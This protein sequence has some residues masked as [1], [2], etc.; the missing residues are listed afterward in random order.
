M[1]FFCHLYLPQEDHNIYRACAKAIDDVACQ[2]LTIAGSRYFDDAGQKTDANSY[3]GCVPSTNTGERTDRPHRKSSSEGADIVHKNEK[4]DE[5][6]MVWRVVSLILE[7]G[8]YLEVEVDAEEHYAERER[9]RVLSFE[10]SGLR[11]GCVVKLLDVC[12][13]PHI[14]DGRGLTWV[15]IG[16]LR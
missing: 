7:V 8:R 13:Q 5:R 9:E 11:A 14:F 2:M 6:F 12:Q 4:A 1:S 10:H 15:D 3:E 16:L